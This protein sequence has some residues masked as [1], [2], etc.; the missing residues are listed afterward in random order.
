MGARVVPAR[1]RFAAG[2]VVTSPA[3]RVLEVG[4]GPGAAAELICPRLR[5][6]SLLAVDR[7]AVAV[8]RTTERNAGHVRAG[9]LRVRRSALADLV[10]PGGSLDVAFTVNVN[11]FWTG[12]PGPELAVLRAALAP[13]GVLHV[14]YEGPPPAAVTAGLQRHGW[15]VA[16]VS[17]TGGAGVTAR[18]D[19]G[20]SADHR[21]P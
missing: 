1:V 16:P 3:D 2:L 7:S 13:G 21:T 19:A 14:L 6:G 15:T 9:V 5:T 20:G 17:G 10:L 11:L 4:C 12:D 8:R 18:P